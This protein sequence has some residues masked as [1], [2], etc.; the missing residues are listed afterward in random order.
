MMS[1]PV[2]SEGIRSGVN[3]MR[4]NSRPSVCA[5]V[6]TSSVFAVPGKSGDQ[7]MAADE[8]RDQ[9]LFEHFFLADDDLPDLL[10][11]FALGLLEA[12]DAL[13]QFRRVEQM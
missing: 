8:Q 3:W 11:D 12:G 10:D 4:W 7:A 5:M 6:R 9:Y 13:L 2:M 1:V